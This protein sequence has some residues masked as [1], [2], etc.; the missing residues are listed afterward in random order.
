[1]P[2][3]PVN[4]GALISIAMVFVLGCSEPAD[5]SGRPLASQDGVVEGVK[6]RWTVP[7]GMKKDEVGAGFALRG[8]DT[9]MPSPRLQVMFERGMPTSV[10]AAV[11]AAS[12]ADG[13]VARQ[14]AIPGGFIVS[15]HSEKND[16]IL[17]NVWKEHELG[18]L[19]CQAAFS[20]SRGIPSFDKTLAMLEKV[21][22]S[23]GVS[24]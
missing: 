16:F 15:G 10:H 1:M 7:E 4:P 14:E 8:A 24:E 3:R 11:K 23:V 18:A 21:C 6:F 9:K 5:W 20:S 13:K 19:H 17:I 22:L 12:L 2:A